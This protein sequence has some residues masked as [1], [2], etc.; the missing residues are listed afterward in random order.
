MLGGPTDKN[1]WR[2]SHSVD[3]A[4][5]TEHGNAMWF[6]ALPSTGATA[7]PSSTSCGS[8]R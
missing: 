1:R 6:E 2:S 5:H 8:T 3:L 7:V 4:D